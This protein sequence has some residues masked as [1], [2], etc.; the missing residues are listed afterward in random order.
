MSLVVW[1]LGPIFL[2][3]L[4]LS[5][6]DLAARRLRR[7]RIGRWSWLLSRP[8]SGGCRRCETTWRYVRPHV[9]PY[10]PGRGMMALC[11][12]CWRDLRTPEAR[13]PF[14][15]D[16]IRDW[17]RLYEEVG[18]QNELDRIQRAIPDLVAALRVGQ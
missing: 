1:I 17:Q 5:L 2:V 14:Y 9:T 10:R 16:V 15:V 3:A 7:W 13:Y 4:A 11:E 12:A 8:G 18:D 6:A